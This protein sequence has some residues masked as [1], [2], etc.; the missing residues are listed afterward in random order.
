MKQKQTLGKLQRLIE[1]GTK[2][3]SMAVLFL[4]GILIFVIMLPTGGGDSYNKV[5]L[6]SG[7]EEETSYKEEREWE[8][9]SFLE[10]VSGVGEV[11]VLIYFGDMEDSTMPICGIAVAAEGAGNE[12]VRLLIMKIVM[13]LYGIDAN[14]VEVTVLG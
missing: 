13:A 9:K 5:E 8:L 14:K 10:S 12:N 11:N 2:K 4:C 7:Y 6:D 1:I 3:E